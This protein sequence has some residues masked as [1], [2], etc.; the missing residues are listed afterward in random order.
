M[1]L[2]PIP[3]PQSVIAEPLLILGVK[4]TFVIKPEREISDRS[5]AVAL[6]DQRT[7]ILPGDVPWSVFKELFFHELE[8]LI[9]M[10]S[11]VTESIS[12]RQEEMVCNNNGFA[13]ADI[14]E[15]PMAMKKLYDRYQARHAQ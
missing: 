4:I 12:A 2:T 8:H 6:L 11:G 3:A 9:L 7:C 15:P 1:A 5:R 10:I 13:L 14:L